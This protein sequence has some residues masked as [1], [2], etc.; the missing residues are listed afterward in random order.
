MGVLALVVKCPVKFI[1]ALL[2][3][4]FEVYTQK[5]LSSAVTSASVWVEDTRELIT[6]V[7]GCPLKA[8]RSKT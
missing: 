7:L 1:S 4:I 5:K 8:D 6:S 3:I 2:I